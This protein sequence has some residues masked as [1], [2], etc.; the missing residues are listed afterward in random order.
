MTRAAGTTLDWG[1]VVGLGFEQTGLE[2]RFN[3]KFE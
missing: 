1:E 3:L 2:A